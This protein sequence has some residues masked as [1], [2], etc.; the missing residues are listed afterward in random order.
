MLL[1]AGAVPFLAKPAVAQDQRPN[2]IHIMTDDHAL[3]AIS[4]LGHP[5]SRLAPT[6][7][8][9]RIGNEGAIFNN[10]FVVNSLSAPSRATLLTGKY[11]HVNG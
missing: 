3:Q 8:I 9:D 4:C 5:L 11:T 10:A 2:I 6:P 7:N 1:L